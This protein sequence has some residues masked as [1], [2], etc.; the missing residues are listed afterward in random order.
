MPTRGGFVVSWEER[1]YLKQ[2]SY[3]MILKDL[4]HSLSQ[5][6]SGMILLEGRKP[7]Q[8]RVNL[9]ARTGG[10]SALNRRLEALR[11]FS[12]AAHN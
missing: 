5:L 10:G 11:M 3:R 2:D 4:S 9:E 12:Q 7:A 8:C 1:L 6:T